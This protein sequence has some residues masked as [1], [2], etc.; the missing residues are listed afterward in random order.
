M[1]LGFNVITTAYPFSPSV[2]CRP[3]LVIRI[4]QPINWIRHLESY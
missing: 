2:I 4:H 3:L 1:L